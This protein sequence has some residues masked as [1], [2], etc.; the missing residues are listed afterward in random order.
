MP[1]TI[2]NL[3]GGSAKQ[4]EIFVNSAE[5]E[6]TLEG[7][8]TAR[9][10]NLTASFALNIDFVKDYV[11]VNGSDGGEEI[12]L[13]TC[14]QLNGTICTDQQKCTGDSVS[15]TQGTCCLAKCE[16]IGEE[17][18]TGK[19]IGWGIV[20]V[21]L[22]LLFWFFKRYKRVRPKVDLLKIGQRR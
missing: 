6:M 7:K 19:Y 16:Q 14:P 9:A 1:E 10:E 18:S 22:I 20:I 15:V 8:I 17:S 5:E 12:V 2:D 13:T 11:P 3:D 4:I 21:V